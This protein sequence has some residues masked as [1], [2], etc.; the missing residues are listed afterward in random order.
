MNEKSAHSPPEATSGLEDPNGGEFSSGLARVS[1]LFP[2]SFLRLPSP[3]PWVVLRFVGSFSFGCT[4]DRCID[5]CFNFH[6]SN[7][8]KIPS[9][10]G[11][12]GVNLRQ[13]IG[14]CGCFGTWSATAL[15]GSFGDVEIVV[16]V[17]VNTGDAKRRAS[18][19]EGSAESMAG[20]QR[21]YI[22]ALQGVNAISTFNAPRLQ[23][24]DK[25]AG[26]R[27]TCKFPATE[28]R[29]SEFYWFHHLWL[30]VFLSLPG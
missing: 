27:I 25:R 18:K 26:N 17:V 14:F 9:S 12:E 20:H 16:V 22:S 19:A 13:H 29:E 7:E 30:L 15:N 24:T 1:L 2:A 28:F 5:R 21:S 8:S 6:S 10:T 23:G 3:G 4:G 11:S